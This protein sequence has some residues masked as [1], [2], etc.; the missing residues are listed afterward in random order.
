MDSDSQLP[1]LL[2]TPA[3]QPPLAIVYGVQAIQT[4]PFSG[5]VGGRF[6][7][8]ANAFLNVAPAVADC[9]KTTPPIATGAEPSNAV[10]LIVLGV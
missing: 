10:P 3:P 2:L 7:G 1:W 6:D 4:V 8:L 9:P 5:L